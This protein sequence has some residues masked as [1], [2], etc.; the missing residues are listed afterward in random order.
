MIILYL[1]HL[2][3]SA[4]PS[5]IKKKKEIMSQSWSNNDN[6]KR[7]KGNSYPA[8]TRCTEHTHEHN[9]TSKSTVTQVQDSKLC[10]QGQYME[11]SKE[12]IEKLKKEMMDIVSTVW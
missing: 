6:T 9:N 10:A 2:W 5:H 8:A 11:L 12:D 1:Q 4:I 3:S 7:H